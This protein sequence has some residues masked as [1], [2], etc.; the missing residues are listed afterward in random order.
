[1]ARP[2]PLPLACNPQRKEE[3]LVQGPH[4]VMARLHVRSAHESG[5]HQQDSRGICLSQGV[6]TNSGDLV[7]SVATTRAS[8]LEG[9]SDH[10]DPRASEW[11]RVDENLMRRPHTTERMMKA[12]TRLRPRVWQ[13]GSSYQREHVRCPRASRESFRLATMAH[14]SA[15]YGGRLGW[16]ACFWAGVKGF[17][18]MSTQVSFS[19]LYSFMFLFYVF[20]PF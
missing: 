7:N 20:F 16:C 15:R 17:R 11:S 19:F 9:G 8:Q 3:L 4:L 14:T 2:A 10:W 6:G 5:H 18:P 12:L 1:M 13:V